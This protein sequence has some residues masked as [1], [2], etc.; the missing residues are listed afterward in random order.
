ME[1]HLKKIYRIF[2]TKIIAEIGWNHMGDMEV[3][4]Q[5]I[6]AAKDC[7][8]DF[9]KFQTWNPQ[10]LKPGPWDTDGRRQI[11]EKAHLTR[12]M[13]IQLLKMCNE[14]G[15]PFLTSVFNKD[16]VRFVSGLIDCI[17][18]P[19]SEMRNIDLINEII[20]CFQVKPTHHIYISTGSSLFSEV[21]EI[22]QLLQNAN[23]S[24]TLMH[25]VSAYPCPFEIC[26]L[27]RIN[28]L[29][30]LHGSV[31]YSGHCY[32]IFDAIVS[33]EYEVDVIE[34]HFTIDHSLPGRDNQFAILPQELNNLCKLRDARVLLKHFNGVDY[35][36]AETEN[37]ETY[38][39]R[40]G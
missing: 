35:H 17:K 21:K 9:V 10:K 24:F 8:A 18:V 2:M 7:G 38:S 22:T 29:R 31:G 19:S 40:W 3:A 12:E 28:E 6:L 23:M 34:K 26:N 33:L 39:G 20:S 1:K 15:I 4:H 30:K 16:D 37:R 27:D 13:H 32:G 36:D 11:Y 5:M 14:I 25:C